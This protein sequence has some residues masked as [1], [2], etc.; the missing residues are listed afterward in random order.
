MKRFFYTMIIICLLMC[1]LCA[2]SSGDENVDNILDNFESGKNIIDK[3]D[4]S[5]DSNYVVYT[6]SCAESEAAFYY[7][8]GR[9]T[10]LLDKE[11]GYSIMLCTKANCQ[12]DLEDYYE[13]ECDAKFYITRG[14]QMYDGKLYA[15]CKDDNGFQR[16][17]RM[18]VDGTGREIVIDNIF[19]R[20]VQRK[21]NIEPTDYRDT[22]GIGAAVSWEIYN[23]KIYVT[24]IVDGKEK[25]TSFFYVDV[26]DLDNGKRIQELTEETVYGLNGTIVDTYI[27][28]NK[29]VLLC[30]FSEPVGNGQYF[31]Y[32]RFYEVDMNT[33]KI[34]ELLEDISPVDYAVTDEGIL[35]SE[36]GKDV[37]L[38]DTN[39][40]KQLCIELDDV[41]KSVTNSI[42]YTGDYIFITPYFESKE[43]I[44]EYG[45]YTKV[46]DKDYKLLDTIPLPADML[47][48]AGH[49]QILLKS[50]GGFEW[51]YLDPSQIGTGNVEIKKYISN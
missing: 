44:D 18:N 22:N 45:Y 19:E 40:D 16:L 32:V 27:L 3:L 29:L 7:Y 23:D 30:Y 24:C 37:Y 43:L 10:Y 6:Q 26:Y 34:K 46:Y 50:R 33:G 5:A 35:Y 31:D 49:N 21:E 25:D 4:Q 2:C 20:Y 48:K 41:E 11:S 47:P 8:D 28:Q 12:H 36:E 38:L 9:Y 39:G 14:M 42:T 13:T 1:F 17:Y 15:D 51:Y